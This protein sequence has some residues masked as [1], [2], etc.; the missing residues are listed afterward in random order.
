[1]ERLWDNQEDQGED[2]EDTDLSHRNICG[3]TVA[4]EDVRQ[5]MC[6]RL[7]RARMERNTE[8]IMDRA[9]EIPYSNVLM[10]IFQVAPDEVVC[11]TSRSIFFSSLFSNLLWG[12]ISKAFAKSTKI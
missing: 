1:M 12:T 9:L 6:R 11:Y 10:T 5:K 4:T 8:N 3:R 2:N 7:Q